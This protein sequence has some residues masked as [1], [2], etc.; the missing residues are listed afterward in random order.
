MKI[1]LNQKCLVALILMLMPSIVVFALGEK[2]APKP[3][4]PPFPPKAKLL[5]KTSNYSISDSAKRSE[6]INYFWTQFELGAYENIDTCITRLKALYLKNPNDGELALLIAQ[7]HFWRVAERFRSQQP[8]SPSISDDL[9][10]AE[11]YLTEAKQLRPNDLRINGWLAGV[12]M[13]LASIHNNPKQM[14]KAYSLAKKSI[15][16]YPAFNHF[17]V[18]YL[19]SNHP[20]DHKLFQ[21]AIASFY[22]SM[23]IAT[24]SR[25]NQTDFDYEQYL[26]LKAQEKN[27]RIRR[28]V[29]NGTKARHNLEGFFLIMGDFL[30]KAGKTKEALIAYNNAKHIPSYDTWSYQDLLANRI[31]N[32]EKNTELFRKSSHMLKKDP[33]NI[34]SDAFDPNTSMVFNSYN[35]TICH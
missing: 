12:K 11:R 27:P 5:S 32:V 9:I 18:A 7:A 1:A 15:R 2:R 8:P 35:C 26:H 17:S 33:S 31:Q 10:I 4:T 21:K 19:F 34:Y 13:S 28:A 25:V 29:W 24:R 3:P 16:E 23:N 14:R 20:H 30:T 22:T 6:A